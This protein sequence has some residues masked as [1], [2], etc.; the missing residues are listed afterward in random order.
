NPAKPIIS[1]NGSRWVGI[2]VPDYGPTVEPSD[3]VGPFIRK[4]DGMG[5]LCPRDL[6][7]DG[8]FREHYEPLESPVENVLHP[9]VRS[10]P[11]ARVF[12]D[13]MAAF[14]KASDFPYVATTY[15]L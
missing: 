9:K 15:R 6:M 13:D 11:A 1:W 10:N 3:G 12:A 7:V 2:D 5:R 4:A 8:P 14:G